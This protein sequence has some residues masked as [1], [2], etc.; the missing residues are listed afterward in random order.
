MGVIHI[1]YFIMLCFVVLGVLLKHCFVYILVG[2]K[3]KLALIVH[4]SASS[5][6]FYSLAMSEIDTDCTQ[7]TPVPIHAS[8]YKNFFETLQSQS[9]F[10]QSVSQEQICQVY[11]FDPS[12][13]NSIGLSNV[14]QCNFILRRSLIFIFICDYD[15]KTPFSTYMMIRR[16]N[17]DIFS[18]LG[19]SMGMDVGDMDNSF[20]DAVLIG[21]VV[22]DVRS[23]PGD[24]WTDSKNLFVTIMQRTCILFIE[25]LSCYT[26]DIFHL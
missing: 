6:L 17:D 11:I 22:Q 26:T 14:A 1:L 8:S 16:H 15:C 25:Q 2:L 24:R 18:F 9:M 4:D 10:S 21:C 7:T 23:S 20:L 12:H 13:P 5:I 19:F 3:D